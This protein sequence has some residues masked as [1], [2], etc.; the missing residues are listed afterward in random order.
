MTDKKTSILDAAEHLFALHGYDGTTTRKIAEQAGV[1]I[2]MLAYYFG[3]KEKLLA[4]IM[5][6]FADDI[7]ALLDRVDMEEALPDKR[8]LRWTDAYL[9]YVFAHHKPLIIAYRE[10][11]LINTRPQIAEETYQAVARIHSHI[12]EVLKEG[13]NRGVFRKFDDK[14]A[15]I[16]MSAT[17]DNVILDHRTLSE[18]LELEVPLGEIYPDSFKERVKAHMK[19]LIARLILAE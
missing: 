1:N 4:A 13:Q 2:A 18:L 3:S 5:Q 17:I 9:D 11:G 14:L 15:I 10:F 7:F 19:D 12:S 6:R 8:L 16:T